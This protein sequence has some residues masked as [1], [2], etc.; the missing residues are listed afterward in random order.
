[1]RRFTTTVFR[2]LESASP[3][4]KQAIKTVN[5]AKDS[6]KPVPPA[7]VKP[8]EKHTVVDTTVEEN[9]VATPVAPLTDLKTANLITH[10]LHQY[11][12]DNAVFHKEMPAWQSVLGDKV[13]ST[14]NLDM[15]RI[16]SG[17]VAGSIYRDLCKSQAYF[18]KD[19]PMT[20]SA[21]FY[22]KRLGM[23]Q[24]FFQW[25][26]IEALHIW[27]L[28]VRMRVMPRKY[29]KEYQ[30]KLVN[31]VFQDIDYQLREVLRVDS[32][33]TTNNYKKQFSQQLRGSVFSYDEAILGGDT[34]LASAL[35]RNLYAQS[36]VVDLTV[37]EHLVQ[38][39][40]A[41]LYILGN[42]SDTDFAGGLFQF[43]DIRYQ[44]EPLSNDQLSKLEKLIESTRNSSNAPGSKTVLSDEGW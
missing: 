30:Q 18:E 2:A 29:C 44:Y 22:Y 4:A 33:R 12:R 3:E 14:F 11:K 15:D 41:N 37:L 35:W 10:I 6:T 7:K 20:P 23:P 21:E 17:P 40:R 9:L 1:M 36:D 25:F 31:G 13:I 39:V 8:Y 16:R 26:Q 38:Y 28:Y 43:L 32:D 24:T 34:V 5:A 42:M 19:C 27:M